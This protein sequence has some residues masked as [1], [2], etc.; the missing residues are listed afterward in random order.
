MRAILYPLL[1]LSLLASCRGGD[2]S[3]D[4]GEETEVSVPASPSIPYTVAS[5]HAHDT[6]AFT[7]GL[8]VHNGV[9]YEST[10]SPD[11]LPQTRSLLGTVDLQTG[12]I[13]TKAELDRRL[14][15]GEGITI[16]NGKVYQLTYQTRKGFVYDAGNFKKLGEFTFPSAEGWGMTTDG[17]ALIMSDGTNRLTYLDPETFRTLKVVEVTDERG[18]VANLNE[19]EFIDDA[20]YA[21]VY[22]TPYIVRIDTATGKVTGRLDLSSLAYEARVRYPGSLELNGIAYDTA[23]RKVFVTGK[24][25]P[26]IYEIDFNH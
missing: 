26:S 21:N 9:L 19:L 20:I 3:D 12:A 24:M 16:L 22:T 25:W 1:L 11:D 23:S 2:E 4:S 13:T 5:R 10:G 14:Y 7:E 15:F 8:L 17:T 18:A 6:T